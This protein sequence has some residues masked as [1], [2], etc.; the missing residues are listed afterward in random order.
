[1]NKQLFRYL[2]VA[3]AEQNAITKNE[4]FN[5]SS[6]LKRQMSFSAVKTSLTT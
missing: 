6:G 1:M 4:K 5:A 2:T 3:Q